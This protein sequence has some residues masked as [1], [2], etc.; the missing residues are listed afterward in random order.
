[1]EESLLEELAIDVKVV[2]GSQYQGVENTSPAT[3]FKAN[4]TEAGLVE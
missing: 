1:M 4:G 2:I 3:R